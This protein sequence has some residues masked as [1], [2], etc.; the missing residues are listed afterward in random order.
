MDYAALRSEALDLLGRLCGNQWTDY[1][2]HD[3]GIT[4]LEQLCYAITDL[5]YRSDFAIAD[6]IASSSGGDPWPPPAERILRGDPVTTEDLL[7]QLRTAAAT[8][9]RI[10]PLEASALTLYFH[11]RDSGTGSGELRL[12]PP[13]SDPNAQPLRPRGLRQV[14][15]Q[16][17]AILPEVERL[18]HQARLL[19]EDFEVRGL[20]PFRVAVFADLEVAAVDDPE[21]LV[22]EILQNLQ[23]TI[24]PD[25]DLAAAAGIRSSDLL[26]ALL[27]LPP[28]RA[29]R[30]LALAAAPDAPPAERKPWLLPIPAGVAPVIDPNSPI[31]LFRDGVQLGVDRT[32]VL[33]RWQ[34]AAELAPSPQSPPTP[35]PGRRRDLT[36]FRSLRRQL[37]ATYGVGPDGLGSNASP[38]RRAQ[39]LQL[40]AYLLIFDQL[41]SNTLAQLALAPVLLS[42]SAGSGDGQEHS[43]ASR[44]MEDP[45]LRFDTLIDLPVTEYAANMRQWVEPGDPRERRQRFLAHL[46]ARFGEELTPPGADLLSLRREFLADI[47]RMGGARGSGADMLDEAAGPGGFEERLRRKLG[48]PGFFPQNSQDP[49]FLVIDHI[50]L[51]PL[52]EDSAQ[53]SDLGDE[54]IPFL[55]AVPWPDPWSLRVT[56]VVNDDPGLKKAAAA[57][58]GNA[59]TLAELVARFDG[60]VAR[61]FAT[62]LPAHLT[63]HLLWFGNGGPDEPELWK[64][65]LEAWRAF[66]SLL[67]D[68]YK[69]RPKG[70]EAVRSLQLPCRDARDRVIEL[71][72]HPA[73][74]GTSATGLGL[75]WPL[76]DIPVP[77]QLV[78]ASGLPATIDLGVSQDGG[79]C[80]SQPG[81]RY[82]LYDAATGEPVQADPA[83]PA[84]PVVAAQGTGQTK[85]PI[86]L[87]T[88]K[89]LKDS[90]YRVR[91]IKDPVGPLG[92]PERATWLRGEIRVIEGID[93]SIVAEFRDLPRVDAEAPPQFSARLCDHGLNVTVDIP[94][95]QDGIEYDLIVADPSLLKSRDEVKIRQ[96]PRQSTASVRGNG[97]TIS[98]FYPAA[99]EDLDL[100]VRA[101]RTTPTAVGPQVDIL[102]TVLCLRVRPDRAVP[103]TV[104]KP[105]RP[106]AELGL[107][108]VGG[109]LMKTQRGATYEL[110]QRRIRDGEFVRDP[111]QPPPDAAEPSL[112]VPGDGPIIRVA[113]PAPA[114]DPLVLA[115]LGFSPAAAAPQLGNGAILDFDLGPSS[116]D[117]TWVALASKQHRLGPLDGSDPR[118]GTSRVQLTQAG[119]Q[120]VRPDPTVSLVLVRW[121]Q[122]ARGGSWRMLGGEPGVFYAFSRA[123]TGL[124]GEAYVHQRD[125]SDPSVAKGVG[126]LRLEVDLAIA[127]AALLG[128]APSGEMPAV[129]LVDLALA[130]ADLAAPV[131]VRARR[132]MTGLL[133]DL[134]GPPLLVRV[135]PPVVKSGSP[136]SIQLIGRPG[137]TYALQLGGNPVG[138]PQPGAGAELTFGTDPL[139]TTTTFQLV[140]TP[141]AGGVRRVPVPVRVEV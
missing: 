13:T 64:R 84:S 30:S 127:A 35:L 107:L 130:P 131:Q 19:G 68:Y 55:A 1:N 12:E 118:T 43:Y 141:Q 116:T 121:Q 48:L 114:A 117:T 3:P 129:V 104:V 20:D 63:P 85:R 24:A 134:S 115:S 25:A 21:G 72:W 33:R 78:V 62:E 22:L 93:T 45:P 15:V 26:H 125:E 40:Q 11:E 18:L 75:P 96:K 36:T 103:V 137:D 2:V 10:A 112:S 90:I 66:R 7:E 37:P 54:S 95:S 31:R 82:E 106:F 138:A 57:G 102:A 42:A 87:I 56:L 76:R 16:P 86:Q 120:L 49:P 128:V 58:M 97:D 17:P 5:A 99:A 9:L 105:V 135:E 14:L 119:L 67:K 100:L 34:P 4:I 101:S 41:F 29:V 98:L 69:A 109:T 44:P 110:W 140:I 108:Q 91:A 65:M 61:T 132:A 60:L 92:A 122:E 94:A 139:T 50:L 73:K 113:R 53:A 133:A 79:D 81:V 47:A 28:V 8:A 51:R 71:L 136:A 126:Q 52:P 77:Q 88:P 70:S 6:L 32:A 124:G 39:A 111:F 74:A 80:F 23:A 123:A 27:D 59:T 46:L 89:I 38:E 83:N